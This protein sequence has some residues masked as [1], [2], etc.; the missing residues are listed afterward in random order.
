M[1]VVHLFLCKDGQWRQL[2]EQEYSLRRYNGPG[3]SFQ[4]LLHLKSK[5]K[6]S[7]RTRK[8]RRLSPRRLM[9]RLVHG[10]SGE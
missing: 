8:N 5:K 7:Q 1:G 9:K 4:D 3:Q 10:E 6:M 2:R